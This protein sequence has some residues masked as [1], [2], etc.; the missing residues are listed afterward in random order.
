M[1]SKLETSLLSLFNLEKSEGGLYNLK[2]RIQRNYIF[3][4]QKNGCA[5]N[6]FEN[7]VFSNILLF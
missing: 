3:M 7:D 2:R 5:Y 4:D 6:Y 1:E